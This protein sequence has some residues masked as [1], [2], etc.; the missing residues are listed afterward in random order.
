[1]R[2]ESFSYVPAFDGLRGVAVLPVV[3]LHVGARL[4]PDNKLLRELT[5]G[6]YGVDLFFVLSG[7]LITS[8]LLGEL[9]ATGTID[10]R[11]FYFRRLLRLMP[12]YASM[13][14][15][16]LL[17]AA[18]FAP[19][20]LREVPRVVPSLLTGTYNYQ[21]ALGATHFGILVV[22][23][24]LCVEQQFYLVWP[25]VLRR[26]DPRRATRWL[27]GA[28]AAISAYRTALYAFFN[29][30]HLG[31]PSPISATWIYFATD[32]RI[33]VILIGCAAA[34][35]LKD[36]R[37]KPFWRR[38]RKLPMFSPMALAA[39]VG[40][41]VFVT[42]GVPSSASWRSATFGYSLAGAAT[43]VL[44][45]AVFLQPAS[46][47]ARLLSWS[48][49]VSLGTISYGVYLF[50]LPMFCLLLNVCHRLRWPDAALALK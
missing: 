11:R 33:E 28:V 7:F 22:I 42:G 19:N 12:A 46:I 31:H 41:I 29:W 4:L 15:A 10:I 8:I 47:V 9:E 37:I 36:R 32:T 45:M 50:H 6:W 25:W 16:V 14:F 1:L 40:C 26:L 21:I 20:V 18:V 48:P 23:W 2:T 39:A 3:L 24:S 17:G 49:L 34:L 44:V 5:R 35:S 30:G 38:M 13:L 43:A 27:I